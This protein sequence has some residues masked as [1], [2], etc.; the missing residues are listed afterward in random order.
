MTSFV[1][2]FLSVFLWNFFMLRF[3][4]LWISTPFRLLSERSKRLKGL[5]SGVDTG[6]P[7]SLPEPVSDQWIPGEIPSVSEHTT[8]L[9]ADSRAA[10]QKSRDES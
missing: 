6:K 7:L 4:I 2:L 1:D 10:A 3:Q 9:L 8:E 5:K